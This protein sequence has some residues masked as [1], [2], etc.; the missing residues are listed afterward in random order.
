MNKLDQVLTNNM[1]TNKYQPN[2]AIYNDLTFDTSRFN[3]S[4][5]NIEFLPVVTVTPRGGKKHRATIFSGL[6]FLLYSG[7][8]YITIK[9]KHTKHYER[10]MQS[11]KVYYSTAIGMYFTTHDVNVPFCMP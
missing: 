11:N 3:L 8:T 4:I 2:D 7:S 5:G 9:Q 1:K 6:I 10:K